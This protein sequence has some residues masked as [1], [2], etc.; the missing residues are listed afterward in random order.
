MR[1]ILGESQ[2]KSKVEND[3]FESRLDS[4]W[5]SPTAATSGRSRANLY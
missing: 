5:F 2:M 4:D 3:L 1:N